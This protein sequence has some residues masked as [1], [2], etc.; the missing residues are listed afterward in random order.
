LDH[1]GLGIVWIF[2]VLDLPHLT[3][4][5]R[6]L[7]KK[8]KHKDGVKDVIA[9]MKLPLGMT[10]PRLRRGLAEMVDPYLK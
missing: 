7:C 2:G 10:E 8:K 5:L 1:H 3:A 6:S 4:I 9:P